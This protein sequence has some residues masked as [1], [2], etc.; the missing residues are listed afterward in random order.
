M[1]VPDSYVQGTVFYP[2]SKEE[3]ADLLVRSGFSVTIGQWALSLE[4]WARSFK[5]RYVGNLSPDEQFHVDGDG[6]G[7]PVDEIARACE[8]LAK[9]LRE[10][11]IGYE[12]FHITNGDE[13]I[14]EYRFIP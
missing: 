12:F 10:H 8:R 4:D 9:C 13:V 11:H 7:L 5:L 3:L 6:Y 14:R 2:E 1:T